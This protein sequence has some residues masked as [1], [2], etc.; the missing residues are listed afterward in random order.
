[1]HSMK[2][3]SP[4]LEQGRRQGSSKQVS[5]ERARSAANRASDARRELA[6]CVAREEP[7]A[8]RQLCLASPASRPLQ[9]G[10]DEA[11]SDASGRRREREAPPRARRRRPHARSPP[12]EALDRKLSTRPKKMNLRAAAGATRGASSR[13]GDDPRR[14]ENSSRA[15]GQ[16]CAQEIVAGP[17]RATCSSSRVRAKTR[18]SGGAA[19][20]A[21]EDDLSSVCSDLEPS[22]AVR[23]RAGPC[24]SP[25]DAERGRARVN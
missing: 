7:T 19:L 16:R 15:R 25:L 10:R 4:Q 3:R 2:Q 8:Q 13:A 14:T 12:S 23:R 22:L 21:A 17:A 24:A 11:E 9:S 1:M 6:R 18:S 20:A 5:R